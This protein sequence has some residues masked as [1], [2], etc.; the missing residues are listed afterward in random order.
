MNFC[1]LAFPHYEIL[2][3]TTSDPSFSRTV[4]FINKETEMNQN[5]FLLGGLDLS[6]RDCSDE[7]PANCIIS[8][9]VCYQ[10]CT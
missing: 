4:I 9:K 3:L 7:D 1:T 10:R 2:Y 8:I 6:I 5:L